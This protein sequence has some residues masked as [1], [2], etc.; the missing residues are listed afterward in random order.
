[1]EELG[2]EHGVSA[3]LVDWAIAQRPLPGFAVSGDRGL[4]RTWSGGVLACA[5]DGLGHGSDAAAAAEAALATIEENVGARVDTLFTRC[6]EALRKTRGVAM[7]IAS[8]R[9]GDNLM[10]WLGVGNVEGVLLRPIPR[11]EWMPLRAGVVGYRVPT[12]HPAAVPIARG[13]VLILVTDGIRHGFTEGL[14]LRA[15]PSEVADHIL[16]RDF[17]GTDDALVLVARYLG[18]KE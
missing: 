8:I 17:R 7:S 5:V 1:M 14:D 13:D 9:P 10:F 6:H 16:S 15:P 12:L 18:A 4:V 2:R 3:E 11:R